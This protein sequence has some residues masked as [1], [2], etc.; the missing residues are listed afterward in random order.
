M[1]C[2]VLVGG[3]S[4]RMG[5][6]K[7]ELFLDCI[8]AAARPVFEEVIAVHRRD[9]EPLR[10]RTIFEG[11]HED[12]GPLFGLVRAL[13]DAHGKCFVIAVDYALMTSE[14]LTYLAERFE[15]STASALIPVWD[16]RTQP[17]CAG[18]DGS[19]LS[20]V[21]RRI[22]S[23]ER[24]LRSLVASIDAEMVPEAELR[25]RFRGEPLMNVNTP[26]DLARVEK[27]HG[28]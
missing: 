24:D 7:T 14:V 28:R 20:L 3:R 19:L 18:Y 5:S 25:E 8:V 9:G 4:R 26:E 1:N 15:S 10:I 13:A 11:T 17:L 27:A 16:G 23:G 6:S 22:E 21:E 2:Y 12:E